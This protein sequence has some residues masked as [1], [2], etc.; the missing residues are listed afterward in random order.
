MSSQKVIDDQYYKLGK[1]SMIKVFE[2]NSI[3]QLEL[4]FVSI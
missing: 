1:S 2:D 4:A 3:E